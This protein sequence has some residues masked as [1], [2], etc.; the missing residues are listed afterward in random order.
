MKMEVL[1]ADEGPLRSACGS[2]LPERADDCGE[3]GGGG[4]SPSS[5][6]VLSS[7]RQ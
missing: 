7:R 6:R 4:G 1:A 3:G 2:A 5:H